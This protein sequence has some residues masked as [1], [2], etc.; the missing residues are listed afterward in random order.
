MQRSG[1]NLS[2]I[3][4][5]AGASASERGNLNDIQKNSSLYNDPLSSARSVQ[6][7]NLDSVNI[8]IQLQKNNYL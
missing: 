6:P 3:K 4:R 2:S 8:D 1:I 5:F 7:K